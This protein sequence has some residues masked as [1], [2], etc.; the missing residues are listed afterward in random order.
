MGLR[1]KILSGFM[2]LTMMLVVAGIWSIYELTRVGTSVQRFLDENYKS[3]NAGK[4]MIEALEREDSAVLLLLSS[5]WKEGRSILTS[6]DELFQKGFAI[7]QNNVT[8]PGEGVYV[9]EIEAKYK[10][11]KNLWVKPIVDTSK[12]GN[13][14]WYFQ[15]VHQ[16]FQGVKLSVGK[17][18]T[19]N[20]QTMYQT[21]SELK[22]RAHRAVMPGIVAIL[23]ALIFTALFNFFTNHYVISPI[24]TTT[25]A[26]QDFMET[27][28]LPAIQVETHDEL[29]DL[30]SSVQQLVAQVHTAEASK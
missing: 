9:G 26:V 12:E 25:R 24:I 5:E 27:G 10:A 23:A 15:E 18:V 30:V 21:A 13:L 8:I 16:A 3:I 6:G 4:M 20:D 14:A 2:I 1:A 17:L 29:L 22:G 11:Y 28:Q 19:L 7:A